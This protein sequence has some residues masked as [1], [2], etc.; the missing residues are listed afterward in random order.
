APG[1]TLAPRKTAI[2]VVDMQG[3]FHDAT[4]W[5]VPGFDAI[6]PKV[7]RLVA[8]DPARVIFTRFWAPV[9]PEDAP[10]W[11][12]QYYQRWAAV[13]LAR[14]P[15]DRFAL[16]EPLRRYA[17]PAAVVDKTTYSPFAVPAMA[18]A[19]VRLGADTLVLAG[20]ETDACV[21]ATALDAV[22]L[23]FRVVIAADAA[24]SGSP[25][26]HRA[27]VETVYPRHE[28][29]VVVATV[30]DVLAALGRRQDPGNP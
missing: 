6:V 15:R 3:V 2:V 5:R 12:R 30:A 27:M 11:W 16:V 22:D 14:M 24:A 9:R 20:V 10:G 8:W 13:T 28:P 18:Q 25:E 26:A 17:P 23:G 7:E 21:L 1:L 19:L 4:P 29:Q